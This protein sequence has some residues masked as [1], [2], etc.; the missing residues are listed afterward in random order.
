M[1]AGSQ[2]EI[3]AFLIKEEMPELSLLCKDTKRK[4][5]S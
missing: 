2:D 1:R 5:K 3:R 4:K